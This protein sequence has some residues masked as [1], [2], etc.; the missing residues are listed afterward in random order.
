MKR[1]ST[2]ANGRAYPTPSRHNDQNSHS[3]KTFPEENPK[4]SFPSIKEL[5]K[6][7]FTSTGSI[8]ISL[9]R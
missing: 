4:S 6:S 5:F 9:L 8:L 3:Q 1:F 7:A 2:D